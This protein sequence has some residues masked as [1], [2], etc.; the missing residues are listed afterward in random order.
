MTRTATLVLT[1][2]RVTSVRL[3]HGRSRIVTMGPY[4]LWVIVPSRSKDAEVIN[5]AFMEAQQSMER[6][7]TDPELVAKARQHAREVLER[8]A[9]DLSWQLDI[10]WMP[11]EGD[12]Q[13]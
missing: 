12:G 11:D 4:G 5:L 2:P 1:Q 6:A 8:F 3:D 9:L 10:Q 13:H 7:A